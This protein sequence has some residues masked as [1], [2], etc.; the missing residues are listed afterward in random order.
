[1]NQLKNN[2][3]RAKYTIILAWAL[4]VFSFISLISSF[5]QYMLIQDALSGITITEERANAN[6]IREGII[7]IIILILYIPFLTTFIAWFKR[8][9]SNLHKKVIGLSYK[10][11]WG[12]LSWFVPILNLYRPYKIMIE[13][14]EETKEILL[15]TY[16]DFEDELSTE[17]VGWWWSFWIISNTISQVILRYSK[18]A[19]TIYQLK[20]LTV[21]GIISE[22]VSIILFLFIIKLVKDYSYA[23]EL[24]FELDNQ[25]LESV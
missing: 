10:E 2:S 1:M 4:V 13:L 5:F 19:E 9:Y 15:T 21:G 20:I 18:R 12:I 3:K 14:Y 23:E 16:S 11:S 22:I 17:F 25:A 8:A 7:G 24:L 6:D